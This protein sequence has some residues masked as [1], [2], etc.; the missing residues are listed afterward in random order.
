MMSVKVCYYLYTFLISIFR[1]FIVLVLNW[2]DFITATLMTLS[3]LLWD[4]DVPLMVVR[5]HG[6]LGW[7]NLT[8]TF[9]EIIE[10]FA[11][12]ISLR[13]GTFAS[14]L[15]STPWL[16][17][18]LTTSSQTWD[19]TVLSPPSETTWRLLISIPW[20]KASTVTLPTLFYFTS[21]C[22]SGRRLTAQRDPKSTKRK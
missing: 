4:H 12:F 10:C 19:S 5:S 8:S 18:T 11:D 14:R 3:K 6:L 2:F 21:S 9:N 13:A 22:K 17:L 16:S 20:T 7:A 1:I 15:P